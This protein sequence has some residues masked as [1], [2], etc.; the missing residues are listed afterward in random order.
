MA[1]VTSQTYS[2]EFNPLY[3]PF[4]NPVYA[5]LV[6]SNLTWSSS[7]APPNEVGITSFAFPGMG[8][9]SVVLATISGLTDPADFKNLYIS[10]V[11]TQSGQVTIVT[12]IY[13][14]TP[15]TVQITVV[16]FSI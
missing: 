13:P 15:A 2:S 3:A 12:S 11:I 5:T 8:T 7:G 1:V 6:Q 9:G 10:S 4:P 16:V 14:N